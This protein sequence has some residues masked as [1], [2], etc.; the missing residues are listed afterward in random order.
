[1]GL[2]TAFVTPPPPDHHIYPRLN[3][4]HPTTALTVTASL[5]RNQSCIQKSEEQEL[6][7]IWESHFFAG[8]EVVQISSSSLLLQQN[9]SKGVRVVFLQRVV[10]VGLGITLRQEKASQR[11]GCNKHKRNDRKDQLTRPCM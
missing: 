3:L 9:A 2:Y 10:I 4:L 11:K 6:D 1:M 7:V 8:K 5:W